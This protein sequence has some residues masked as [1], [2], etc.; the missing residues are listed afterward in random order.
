M[1]FRSEE[2]LKLGADVNYQDR[3]GMTALHYM[4]K[5]GSDKRFFS[6]LIAHGARGDLRDTRGVCAADLMRKKR[7]SDFRKMAEQL[8]T[9]SRM[10]PAQ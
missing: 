9:R 2:L 5:K 7:D 1:L 8:R 6:M 4:L 3:K 10:M